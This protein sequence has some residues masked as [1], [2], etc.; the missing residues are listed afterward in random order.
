VAGSDAGVPFGSMD[1]KQIAYEPGADGVLVITLDR[2]ERLNA[3]TDRMMAEMLDAFD[4]ADSDDDVRAVIV[5]GRGRAFCAGADL[6]RGGATFDFHEEGGAVRRDSGGRVSL[7]IFE[8]TKPVLAAINGPAVGYGATMTLPMD[9]RMASTE[10]RM[11]FVFV[12]RGIVPE[13]CSSWFLPR[14]VGI[15]RA[16]EWVATGRIF[17]ASDALDAGLVRSVHAPMELLA[18]TRT[19]AREMAEGTSAVSI[20]VSR[21]LLWR[22]LG[23][24]HPM[25]AHRIDSRAVQ[26]LGHGRDAREGVESFLE[27]RPPHFPG[28]VSTDLPDFYPWW[29]ERTFE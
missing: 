7:R 28:R 29:S 3:F 1:Y 9:V 5:T 24:D 6:G 18:A 22:M 4:R 26:A 10:A 17:P 23:A 13:A 21:Q 19:L 8:S 25:E 14:L 12:R 2:P 11:G 20:A 16:M 27:K 15:S